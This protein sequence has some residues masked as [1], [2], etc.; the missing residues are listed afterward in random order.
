MVKD[1]KQTGSAGCMDQRGTGC[2]WSVT[3][4]GE[5]TGV[6][7]E[8]VMSEQILRCWPPAAQGPQRARQRDR[9]Q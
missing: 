6:S 2:G 8:Q 5:V 3:G 9:T 7:M 1:K 4:A